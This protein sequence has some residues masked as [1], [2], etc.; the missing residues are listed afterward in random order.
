MKVLKILSGVIMAAIMVWFLMSFLDIAVD[1]GTANA[2]HHSWNF[3][4]VM[5]GLVA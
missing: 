2:V 5:T 4:L 1:A 3:F